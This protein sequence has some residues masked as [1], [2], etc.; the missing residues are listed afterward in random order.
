MGCCLGR[1]KPATVWYDDFEKQLPRM[2]GKMV[3]ITGTTSGT[4]FVAALACAKK[5][6]AVAL[7]NRASERANDAER[8]LR[9]ECPEAKL[10]VVA[11]D[12]Q[13]FASVRKA[14]AQLRGICGACGLDVL[15]CNA[16]VMAFPDQATGDG[17]DVQMQTNHLSHFLLVKEMMP[18][19]R[20][21]AKSRGQ[22][23]IVNH[24]S[25]A[26]FG[27]PLEARYFQKNGGDLG[28]DAVA[29]CFQRYHQTKLANIVFTFALADRLAARG[30]TGILALCCTP[31][32]AATALVNNL[33]DSG[34]SLGPMKCI[35]ACLG[36][37][38]VQSEQDGT[39]P[40]LHC[41]AMPEVESGEV[42][43][44]SQGMPLRQPKESYGPVKVERRPQ[45]HEKSRVTEDAA[46]QE[47]LWTESERA[48]GEP[49]EL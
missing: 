5:G 20:D 6:A 10:H 2:D 19:L 22:A 14:A 23:R 11:C 46:L 17:F 45:E 29:A 24:S 27:E 18:A 33:E 42:A 39:M 35:F 3:A 8:R 25:G 26:R 31:G 40:L 32:I 15:C 21:A 48:V 4:G 1:D 36:P 12:L 38:I 47:L 9:L 37:C 30:E 49:F 34:T 41:M 16:G 44:P 7:L 43:T 28:G 13:S